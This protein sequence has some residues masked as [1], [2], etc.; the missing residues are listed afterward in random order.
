MLP[1]CQARSDERG[2]VMSGKR[3]Y[4]DEFRL[5]KVLEYLPVNNKAVVFLKYQ[6]YKVDTFVFQ[7]L[8]GR[9]IVYECISMTE[10]I[11]GYTTRS[12][13]MASNGGAP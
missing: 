9:I 10:N 5:N 3:K 7:I 12:N 11:N 8:N 4:T 1:F 13:L 2:F 6:K